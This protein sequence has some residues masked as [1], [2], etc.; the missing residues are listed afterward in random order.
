MVKCQGASKSKHVPELQLLQA[1]CLIFLSPSSV[2]K[3]TVGIERGYF[4]LIQFLWVTGN[5]LLDSLLAG[6]GSARN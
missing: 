4:L 1:T 5:N 6:T 3:H 2:S